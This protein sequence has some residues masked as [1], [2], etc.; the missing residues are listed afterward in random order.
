[1]EHQAYIDRTTG[2]IQA[3][4]AYAVDVAQERVLPLLA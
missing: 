1:M 4:L 2:K 3:A